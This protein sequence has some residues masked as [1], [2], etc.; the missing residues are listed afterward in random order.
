MLLCRGV[1]SFLLLVNYRNTNQGRAG[2]EAIKGKINSDTSEINQ[3]R[4]LLGSLQFL[5]SLWKKHRS[6][7]LNTIKTRLAPVGIGSQVAQA[8]LKL[9]V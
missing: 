8:C 1:Q 7:V 2:C 4:G 9:Q 3:G 6:L 5:R